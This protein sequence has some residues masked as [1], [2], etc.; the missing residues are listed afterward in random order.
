M[1]L[2]GW[3]T[4]WGLGLFAVPFTAVSAVGL[5]FSP[6]SVIYFVLSLPVVVITG[7][8]AGA[9]GGALAA[10]LAPF[11]RR[12]AVLARA[13]GW[14]A[15]A[16]FVV[17]TVA[18]A[19]LFLLLVPAGARPG[20]APAVPVVTL[21]ATGLATWGLALERRRAAPLVGSHRPREPRI[22]AP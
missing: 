7:G 13:L 21:I 1:R 10:A 15:A 18:S 5:L 9:L 11:G 8:A 12:G 16:Y 3:G 4:L 2:I 19:V 14:C 22:H 6:G 20:Q 17:L